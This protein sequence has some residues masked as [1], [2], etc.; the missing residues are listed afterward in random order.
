MD[1]PK[2]QKKY[3]YIATEESDVDGLVVEEVFSSNEF[4]TWLLKKLSLKG[5]A[6]F[7][8]A[9]KIPTYH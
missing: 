6:K 8:G 9:W 3:P 1:L 5:Y 2:N 7:I 4:Q